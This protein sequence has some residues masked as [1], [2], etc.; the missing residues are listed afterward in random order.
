MKRLYVV[1]GV[2]IALVGI[3]VFIKFRKPQDSRQA[4]VSVLSKCAS[5]QLIGKDVLY[6]GASNEIGPGSIWRRNNDGSIRLRYELSDLEPDV[7]KRTALVHP[8][9]SVSCGGDSSANWEVQLG[10]PFE[11]SVTPVSADVSADLK[12]ADAVSVSVNGWAVDELKEGPYETMIRSNDAL[13]DESVQSDRVIV[14]N[15]V[16]IEGFSANF[17]FSKSVADELKGKYAGKLIAVQEGA[18]LRSQWSSDTTLTMKTPD[19][20][21][22]LAAFGRLK[23]QSKAESFSAAKGAP[24]LLNERP[25]ALSD[26]T[27]RAAAVQKIQEAAVGSSQPEE[28]AVVPAVPG[29][30]V[31][32]RAFPNITVTDGVVAVQGTV[33]DDAARVNFAKAIAKAPGVRGISNQ[34]ALGPERPTEAH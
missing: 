15:A 21:Y 5:T 1:F 10:L 34:L 18:H 12:R 4:W 19:T 26:M 14:E 6:F 31:A 30:T 11:G 2:I 24:H 9:N 17:K 33:K 27:I 13:Q 23:G 32:K 29:A 7:A 3:V 28:V 8:N 25:M 20:F 22:I 16:R